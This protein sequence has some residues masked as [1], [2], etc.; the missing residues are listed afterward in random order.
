M[1]PG[2]TVEAD[3]A[4]GTMLTGSPT[5]TDI[6]TYVKRITTRRGRPALD[7]RFQTGTGDLIVD[8][9]DGRF[10][11]ANTAGAYYP[12]VQIGLPVR[13]R[14][15]H[16]L[17][18]YPVFYGGVRSFPTE[19][20]GPTSSLAQLTL[21]DGFYTLNLEDLAGESYPAQ[22]TRARIGAVLDDLSWPAGLRDLDTALATVQATAFAQP[23]T[24]G[25]Q[26]ALMHL[27]DVA[28][29]E[30]GVLFMSRDG[31][32]TFKNRVAMSGV[33]PVASFT[34]AD[35][36]RIKT[37]RDDRYLWKL[38]RISR[39]DGAQV[40]VDASAGRPRRVL[41]RDVMPMGND[42]EAV[43]VAEW[44]SNIF[45]EQRLRI[46]PLHFHTTKR[47][48]ALIG[49]LL[50]LELRDL[51]NISHT[52]TGGDALDAD[53]AAEMIRHTIT[54]RN[55]QTTLDVALLSEFEQQDFWILGTSELGI[56]TVLA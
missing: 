26:P 42:A 17:V 32:V 4:G 11:P 1:F 16:D 45:G 9:S 20:V 41:T 23:E 51:V 25:E 6:T 36:D 47:D 52:P 38:I 44:L 39:E 43:N 50:G 15:T 37:S 56:D 13:I 21:A 54:A 19:K 33:S 27:L 49:P 10:S 3:V 14:A 48:G 24:G 28:E 30:A 12:N 7:G 31:K 22:S 18:T 29:S 35:F 55:W 46:D 5:W 40:E 8:N 53:A 34:G 2:I